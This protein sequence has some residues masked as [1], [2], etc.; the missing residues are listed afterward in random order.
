MIPAGVDIFLAVEPVDMRCGFNRLSGIAREH[1]GYDPRCGAMFVFYGKRRHSVKIRIPCMKTRSS[2][3][4]E[5]VRDRV[6]DGE[7]ETMGGAGRRMAA[8]WSDVTRVL[9]G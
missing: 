9:R 6:H 7:S 1:L 4:G 3:V 2:R 8:Q 5:A